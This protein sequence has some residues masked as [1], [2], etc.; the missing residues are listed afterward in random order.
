EDDDDVNKEEDEEEEHLALAD[1]TAVGLPAVDHAPSAEETEPFETDESATTPP[2]HLAYRVIAWITAY[3]DG[4]TTLRDRGVVDSRPQEIGTIYFTF[5]TITNHLPFDTTI[6]APPL[7]SIP[8]PT[9]S[10]PLLPLSTDPKANVCEEAWGRAMDACDFV[11]SE[12]I[13]LRTQMTQMI[14][15]ERQQ[16]PAK[17]PAQPDPPEEAGSTSDVDRNTNDDDSHV[18]G[19]CVRRTER[20]TRECTY[21][22]FMKCQPLNFK[23][24]E[25]VIELTQWFEKMETVFHIRNCSVENQ[26]KFSTCTLLG[27]ALMWW[28]SHVMTVG[29]DVAYEMT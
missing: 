2:P 1:S 7:L 3:S 6:R 20:V 13:A 10:P 17:G 19:I 16:G 18:L 24:M 8:L 4:S 29:L 23:G 26:I 21:L 27:S 28:N 15:F 22:D 25:G 12:N 5:T 14:E 11:R 9:S